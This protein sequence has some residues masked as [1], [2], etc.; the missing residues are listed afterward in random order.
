LVHA[1]LRVDP[2]SKESY[3]IFT[4]LLH[5]TTFLLLKFDKAI[6]EEEQEEKEEEKEEI[7]FVYQAMKIITTFTYTS[8]VLN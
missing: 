2:W 8:L 6:D 1:L 5:N 3:F 4:R 7:S